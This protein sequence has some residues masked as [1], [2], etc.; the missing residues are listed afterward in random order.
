MDIKVSQSKKIGRPDLGI[1]LTKTDDTVEEKWV[2]VNAVD[3]AATI[4]E[5]GMLYLSLIN[6]LPDRDADVV[7][8]LDGWK[9]FEVACSAEIYH[10]DLSACNTPGAP[11]HRLYQGRGT[12]H[13]FWKQAGSDAEETFGQLDPASEKISR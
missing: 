6:K 3:C 9:E 12:A 13:G 7:I 10:D 5:S 8:D 2:K 11:R 4:D 1:D